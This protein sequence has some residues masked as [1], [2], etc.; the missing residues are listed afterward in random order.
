M[1]GRIG[2]SRLFA[3]LLAP[4]NPLFYNQCAILSPDT[5]E[6]KYG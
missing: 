6:A 1:M 4:E 3:L 2:S 5:D